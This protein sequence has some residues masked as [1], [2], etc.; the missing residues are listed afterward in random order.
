MDATGTRRRSSSACA[1][2]AC[3]GRSG[4]PP[5][6]P[7][8][9][10][11]SSRSRWASR[12]CRRRTRI[13]STCSFEDELPTD[14][15][16]AKVNRHYWRRDYPGFAQFF[17]GAITSEPHSTKVIEDAAGWAVD[18]SVE[19]MLAD[20]EARRSTSIARG[21]RRSAVRCRC[22]MLIVHGT[23]DHCQPLG[24]GAIGWP[25]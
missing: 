22:P 19:A 8:R 17:F 11:G 14:D 18:G 20:A 5:S 6:Q 1:A 7:E 21:W 25:R 9:V 4:S 24:A 13:A 3:G 12:G 2:T 10:A 23:E 16:W 15:G